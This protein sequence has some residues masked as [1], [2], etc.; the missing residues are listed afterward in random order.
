[1]G[2]LDVEQLVAESHGTRT[3]S[4]LDG[5]W[6]NPLG[7]VLTV[8]LTDEHVIRGSFRPEAAGGVEHRSHLVHGYAEG[9]AFTFCVDF[10]EHGSVAS[11]TG[12]HVD[13]EAGDR[14]ETLWQLARTGAP[15]A[16]GSPAWGALLTGA[17]TFTRA[18]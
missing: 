8:E 17:N 9:S 10:G 5:T 6:R 15:E 16:G 3:R 14:L 4:E 18:D 7:S 12:H 2:A 13:D 11:W 1:M